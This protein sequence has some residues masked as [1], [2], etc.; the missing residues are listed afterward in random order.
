ML[1]TIDDY[2]LVDGT[3][4]GGWSLSDF[5]LRM[6]RIF[7]VVIPIGEISPVLYDRNKRRVDITFTVSRIHDSIKDAEIYINEHESLVPRT[8]EIDLIADGGVVALVVNG[9]LLSHELLKQ[10]GA[11]T[12]HAYHITGSPIS[13]PSPPGTVDFLITESGDFL[14]T[15]AGDFIILE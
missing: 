9:E 8:G 5:R 15:E 10:I 3:F 4:S 13:A 14:T 11:Y 1:C 2:A 7:D 12:E 6:Q